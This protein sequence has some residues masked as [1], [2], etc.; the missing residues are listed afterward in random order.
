MSQEDDNVSGDQPAPASLPPLP[1]GTSSEPSPMD[2]RLDYALRSLYN[3][4]HKAARKLISTGKVSV[5][6]ERSLRWE[7]KVTLGELITVTPTAPNPA[8]SE[9]LGAKLVFQDDA[10]AILCKPAGL[11]SAP[12]HD[13]EESAL[14][15][16]SRLCKGPRRPRVVHRLDKETSGLLIFARTVPAARRLQIMLQQREIKRI[17]RCVVRGEVQGEGGYISSR[18]VRDAGHGKRG[19]RMGSLKRHPLRKNRPTEPQLTQD[20]QLEPTTQPKS[21]WALTRYQVISRANGYTALEVELFTGRTHQI[22]IHLYEIGHP[23][24]GEWVYAPRNKREP[25]LALHASR[26]LLHHPF[27]EKELIFE[28]DWPDDLSVLPSVPKAWHSQSSSKNRLT[29]VH[30]KR[31]GT[32]GSRRS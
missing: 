8:K 24:V 1:Q 13:D 30:K 17:Y 2:G 4:S 3:L 20:S 6:G 18:F 28:A 14:Q 26:L 5:S 7:T 22:R 25:R 23:I 16:V 10:L 12:G 11:L 15:A 9:S 29:K 32:K 27:T 31:R 19:S 21:Q